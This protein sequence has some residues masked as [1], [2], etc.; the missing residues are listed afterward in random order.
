[1]PN[2]TFTKEDDYRITH[3]PQVTPREAARLTPFQRKLIRL[4][5]GAQLREAEKCSGIIR[6]IEFD[7]LAGL[8]WKHLHLLRK[9]GWSPQGLPQ[10]SS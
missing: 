1:M 3:G 6:E 7:K 10:V 8:E 5:L 9:M 2:D 4:K